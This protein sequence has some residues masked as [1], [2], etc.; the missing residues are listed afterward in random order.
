MLCRH[1]TDFG[2][3]SASELYAILWISS[4]VV[5]SCCTRFEEIMVENFDARIISA[6]L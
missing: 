5:S 1:R 6:H 3:L 2:V 4:K